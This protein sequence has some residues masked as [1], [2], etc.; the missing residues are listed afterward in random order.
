[1]SVNILSTPQYYGD[2]QSSLEL[3][4]YHQQAIL[5]ATNSKPNELLIINKI[6]CAKQHQHSCVRR[7]DH[8]DFPAKS[9][10][11]LAGSFSIPTVEEGDKLLGE[12]LRT[13]AE[14]Q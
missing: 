8:L 14:Y 4:K 10:L 3:P 9:T 13:P 12:T 7:M 11:R 6:V 2:S 5:P 1:M